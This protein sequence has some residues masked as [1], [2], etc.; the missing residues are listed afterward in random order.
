MVTKRYGTV[1]NTEQRNISGL[2]F[3]Q[4]LVDGSL[5]LNT[6]AKVLGYDVVEAEV[7]RVVHVDLA[8][9]LTQRGEPGVPGTQL[10]VNIKD[11]L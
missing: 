3:V 11:S 1:P 2:T 4:G 6:M 7:G 8:F 5:P 9:P 10:V